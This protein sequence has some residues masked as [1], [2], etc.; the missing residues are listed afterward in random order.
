MPSYCLIITYLYIQHHHPFR[1]VIVFPFMFVKVTLVRSEKI[2]SKSFVV[3]FFTT[4]G[5]GISPQCQSSRSLA[6]DY[7]SKFHCK[8]YYT[9]LTCLASSDLVS[10][11]P[12]TTC[13]TSFSPSS[14]SLIS[15]SLSG[16]LTFFLGRAHGAST[17]PSK[18]PVLLLPSEARHFWLQVPFLKWWWVFCTWGFWLTFSFFDTV[19]ACCFVVAL[20]LVMSE[21]VVMSPHLQFTFLELISSVFGFTFHVVLH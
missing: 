9:L 7:H 8:H 19:L 5:S 21:Y 3:S 12:S 15:S 1:F 13:L 18:L 6:C 16:H 14:T 2:V 11:S 10:S 17:F 4:S 20:G